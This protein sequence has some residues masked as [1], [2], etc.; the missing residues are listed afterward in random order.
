MKLNFSQ[1]NRLD[2]LVANFSTEARQTIDG[3]YSAEVQLEPVQQQ[4]YQ[5]MVNQGRSYFEPRSILS[6]GSQ[7]LLR[8]DF[9]SAH[10]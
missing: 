6:A 5:E 8:T 9:Q 7:D 10:S 2:D 3:C 1:Q 4:R